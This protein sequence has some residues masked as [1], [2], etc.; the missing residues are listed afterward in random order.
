MNSYNEPP[1]TQRK[2]SSYLTLNQSNSSYP[3]ETPSPSPFFKIIQLNCHNAFEVTHSLLNSEKEAAILIL[4]EP[5][6]NPHT[7]KLPTHNSW[8]ALLDNNHAP[9]D[10]HNKHR[11]CFII[12]K[13]YTSDRIHPLD[14]GS[15]ILSALELDIKIDGIDKIRLIN[16]YNP[17]KH[18]DALT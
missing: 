13:R 7:M 11:T 17:P 3:Q 12:N 15:R 1:A 5:W 14:G 8:F 4:Q 16:V 10:Y 6:I 18:F 2:N 9:K